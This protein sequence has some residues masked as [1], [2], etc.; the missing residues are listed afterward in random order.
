[1]NIQWQALVAGTWTDIPGAN[2]ATFTPDVSHVNLQLR[3]AVRFV[4]DIGGQEEV[5]SA[6]TAPVG[7]HYIGTGAA[8]NQSGTSGADILE[9][10]GGADTL[11]GLAGD[12]IINGGNGNDTLNGG[13]GNDQLSGEGGADTLNGGAGDD[14]LFGG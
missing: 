11:N 14:Q 8:N 3:A 12:D 2:S 7:I 9:G 1:F 13:D 10:L 6:A 4:D 5:V